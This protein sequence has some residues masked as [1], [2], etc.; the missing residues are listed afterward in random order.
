MGTW[1]LPYKNLETACAFIHLM[2]SPWIARVIAV[3]DDPEGSGA[4]T[5]ETAGK[6][7]SSLKKHPLRVDFDAPFLNSL[8]GSD[9]I[10]DELGAMAQRKRKDFD[11][12]PI[13][14]RHVKKWVEQEDGLSSRFSVAALK[15][16][17][18]FLGLSP[19]PPESEKSL[20]SRAKAKSRIRPPI[21]GKTAIK[22]KAAKKKR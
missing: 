9:T 4:I 20:A 2:K 3:P 11:V 13:V 21:A 18:D 15:V 17:R 7:L 16:L 22:K 10:L 19:L 8:A 14:A 5:D 6:I 1:A 12:R